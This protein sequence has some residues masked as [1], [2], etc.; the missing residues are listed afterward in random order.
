MLEETGGTEISAGPWHAFA[1]AVDQDSKGRPIQFC[2]EGLWRRCD[3]D[4]V[5]EDL[6]P[7][8]D[9]GGLAWIDLE[10]LDQESLSPLVRHVLG[11]GFG[12]EP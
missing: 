10:A 7:S 5:T 4:G 12:G 11:L 8:E 2:H 3:L 1:L 6:A 9:V